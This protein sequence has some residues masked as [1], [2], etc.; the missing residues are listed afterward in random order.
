M[1]WKGDDEAGARVRAAVYY[2][3]LRSGPVS[4]ARSLVIVD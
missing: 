2:A 4:A 1:L 3:R